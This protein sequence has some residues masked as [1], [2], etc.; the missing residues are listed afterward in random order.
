MHRRIEQNKMVDRSAPFG[1]LSG[2]FQ[3]NKSTN[4]ECREQY[5]TSGIFSLKLRHVDARD[6]LDKIVTAPAP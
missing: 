2:H 1:E 4:T 6:V 3:C 5:W